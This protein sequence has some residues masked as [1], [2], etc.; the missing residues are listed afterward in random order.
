MTAGYI[1][2]VTIIPG[3]AVTLDGLV[4]GKLEDEIQAIVDDSTYSTHYQPRRYKGVDCFG[5]NER[6]G[7]DLYLEG[8]RLGLQ[9]MTRAVAANC[10][11]CK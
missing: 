4:A 6:S 9:I 7:Y 11:T 10:P 3:T 2:L 1:Q 5:R 8:G